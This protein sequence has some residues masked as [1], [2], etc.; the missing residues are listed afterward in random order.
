MHLSPLKVEAWKEQSVEPLTPEITKPVGDVAIPAGRLTV[1][2]AI[3][4]YVSPNALKIP[5][6]A[7]RRIWADKPPRIGRR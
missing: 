4:A 7:P 6:Q 1:V 3:I 2:R 5:R